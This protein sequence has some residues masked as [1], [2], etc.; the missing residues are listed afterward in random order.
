M[1]LISP[2]PPFW[3]AVL[4]APMQ[5]K[6][7]SAIREVAAGAAARASTHP[8]PDCTLAGGDAGTALL[9][10]F[11]SQAHPQQPEW[12]TA[13]E[14]L[15]ERAFDAVQTRPLSASFYS[16]F[17]GV[18]WCAELMHPNGDE[19][20]DSDVD[21]ALLEFVSQRPWRGHFDLINGLTGLGV[22]AL[23]RLPGTAARACLEHIVARLGELAEARPEGITW[24]S[25]PAL[26]PLAQRE[27][28][29]QGQLNLGVAHGVPGVVALLAGSS[30][31]GVAA[32][33]AAALAHGGARW[34]MAQVLP[35]SPGK[36]LAANT[37]EER[38][39]RDAWCY[40][41]PGVAAAMLGA[42]RALHEPTWEDFAL[43]LARDTAQRP[44]EQTGVV[45]AGLC[46][47]AVGLAHL[48]NRLYQASGDLTL[49]EAAVEWYARTLQF[50]RPGQGV[51]AFLGWQGGAHAVGLQ[52]DPCLLTG[53]AGVALGLLAAVSD[54]EPVW[55]R[56]LLSCVAP[57]PQSEARR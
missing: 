28:H 41:T 2:R 44:P 45:D 1:R 51:D 56:M 34:L 15:L 40:G 3:K 8:S 18:A 43:S 57:A 21:T 37:G 12:R 20:H 30:A 48:F 50:Y 39:A 31:A 52:P 38:A 24:R 46:H 47:G 42:A 26:L 35:N 5:A 55:D 17:P 11:M 23:E 29:P 36:R 14:A 27:A 9:L 54:V 53:S 10:A 49:R 32:D 16:G 22:Y 25:A 33:Q 6:A 4:D 13:S 7:L 19:A